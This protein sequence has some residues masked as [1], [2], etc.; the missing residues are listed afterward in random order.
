MCPYRI[1]PRAHDKDDTLCF[2]SNKGFIGSVHQET[3]GGVSRL[4][5]FIQVLEHVFTL[6]NDGRDFCNKTFV[7]M[8]TQIS[9][10]SLTKSFV[11]FGTESD[12][13]I[14]LFPTELEV[15]CQAYAYM[16]A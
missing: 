9:P 8:F 1:I 3:L 7:F 11:I 15:L 5:K 2:F 4:G 13:V 10:E 16:W 14:Q 6:V 12:Q